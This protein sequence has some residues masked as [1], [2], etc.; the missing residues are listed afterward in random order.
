MTPNQNILHKKIKVCI[1][2]NKRKPL[3]RW[4][5]DLF[6]NNFFGAEPFETVNWDNFQSE[7][8]NFLFLYC[9]PDE[10]VQFLQSMDSNFYNTIKNKNIKLLFYNEQFNL[11]M[12][13]G[14]IFQ[15]NYNI[16]HNCYDINDI[17]Y[18]KILNILKKYAIRE[19]MLFFIHSSKGFLDEIEQMK[20]TKIPWIASTWEVKSKH[21][22]MHSDLAWGRE[23]IIKKKDLRSLEEKILRHHYA[24]LFA[25]RPA[26]HRHYLIKNL[27]KKNLLS[28]G[29]C[30]LTPCLD[31]ADK[32]QLPTNDLLPIGQVNAHLV[33]DTFQETKLFQDIFLWVAGETYCPNGYPYFTEKTVKAILYERPFVSYGNPGTLAYLR[34]Y[35]F[36]TFN[37]YWD[38]SYDNEKDDD[39]K[40]EMIAEIIRNLCKKNLKE[41]NQLYDNMKPLLEYNKNLL[42]KTDWRKDLVKFLS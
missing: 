13:D 15:Y 38:E 4:H 35:G 17:L 8:N 33:N 21:L 32:H 27:H 41:I 16:K 18:W 40:I 23:E 1:D 10:T 14:N 42:V 3:S 39:K 5:H 22:Q 37:E 34:D 2:F 36:K 11:F 9:V 28:F 6:T 24:C 25:G 20:K 7:Q 31:E 12:F 30:S 19:E 26:R 29:K